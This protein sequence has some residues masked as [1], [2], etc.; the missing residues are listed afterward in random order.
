MNEIKESKNNGKNEENKK[1]EKEIDTLENNIKNENISDI[2]IKNQSIHNNNENEEIKLLIDNNKLKNEEKKDDIIKKVN[3][4]PKIKSYSEYKLNDKIKKIKNKSLEKK[5]QDLFDNN[6]NENEKNEQDNNKFKDRLNEI[7][8]KIEEINKYNKMKKYKN[9]IKI[10]KYEDQ[11]NRYNSIDKE[12][13]KNKKNPF[14]FD[15]NI[16]NEKYE[17]K[18]KSKFNDFKYKQTPFSFD[19]LYFYNIPSEENKKSKYMNYTQD[20]KKIFKKYNEQRLLRQSNYFDNFNKILFKVDKFKQNQEE[21]KF[22]S[23]EL[24]KNNLGV[25]DIKTIN[26]RN[27]S[28]LINY[29]S[30]S[31]E[32]PSKLEKIMENIYNDINKTSNIPSKNDFDRK[33]I[34][35][36]SKIKYSNITYNK[37]NIKTINSY[38]HLNRNDKLSKSNFSDL[39]NLIRF[40]SKENLKKYLYN[41]SKK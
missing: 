7:E 6:K 36:K 17:S 28:N 21:N 13:E 27:Q 38:N 26:Y 2:N 10:K 1:E 4:I 5:L 31:L 39:N 12:K 41:T 3:N 29:K 19:N 18:N 24:F 9:E 33:L 25:N 23:N 35:I 37:N 30:M 32:K 20:L 22:K 14:Y 40:C 16:K 34:R 11:N 15:Y 8:I